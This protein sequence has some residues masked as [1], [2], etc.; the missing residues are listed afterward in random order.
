MI[1]YIEVYK[2]YKFRRASL[3]GSERFLRSLTDRHRCSAAN[4]SDLWRWMRWFEWRPRW[5]P[6]KETW[7]V[8][9]AEKYGKTWEN[10]GKMEHVMGNWCGQIWNMSWNMW[11]LMRKNDWTNDDGMGRSVMENVSWIFFRYHWDVMLDWEVLFSASNWWCDVPN[12][13]CLVDS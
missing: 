10:H 11:K 3:P 1:L 6:V 9:E 8:F 4:G 7:D 13:D 5:W 12:F 2:W